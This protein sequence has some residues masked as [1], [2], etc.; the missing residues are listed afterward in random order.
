[1]LVYFSMNN[2]SNLVGTLP[3]EWSALTSLGYLR[4]ANN[5]LEGAVPDEWAN[6]VS[7]LKEFTYQGNNITRVG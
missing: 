2:N 5:T 7:G 4:V 3:R 1:M 6:M